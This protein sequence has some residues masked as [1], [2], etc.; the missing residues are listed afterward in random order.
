MH[1]AFVDDW[2]QKG[3]RSGMS[4]LLS[5][6]AVIFSEDQLRPFSEVMH[7]MRDELGIPWDVERKWA[8]PHGRAKNYFRQRGEAGLQDKVRSRI[9]KLAAQY[10]AHAVV[11]VLDLGRMYVSED[12]ANEM[13]LKYLYERIIQALARKHLGIVVFDK[14]GGD[15]QDEDGWIGGTLELSSYGTGFI[16]PDEIVLPILTAPSHHHEHLQL[17]DLVT[18]SV[19]AAVAGNKYGMALAPELKKIM[20][21]NAYGYI[22]GAGPNLLPDDL[23][24]LH[25]HVFGEDTFAKV[26]MN[27]GRGI[28]SQ[29]YAY[30]EDDGLTS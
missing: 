20:H 3:L 28:P 7:A 21:R 14:P 5:L 18:G 26:A 9:L 16:K 25:H 4:D 8:M 24:N 15:H 1:F 11:V 19:T 17:A 23:T 10:E 30:F 22:G 2:K 12:K 27:S 29:R 6:G 13:V